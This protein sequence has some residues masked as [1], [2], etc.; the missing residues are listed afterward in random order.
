MEA[1]LSVLGPG[2]VCLVSIATFRGAHD[3]HTMAAC[4][5]ELCQLNKLVDLE[6]DGRSGLE[7]LAVHSFFL[8]S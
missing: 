2:S 4:V 8:Y 5:V 7:L 6:G 3:V 1:H